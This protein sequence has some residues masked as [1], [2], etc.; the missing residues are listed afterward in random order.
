M[1]RLLI[2]RGAKPKRGLLFAAIYHDAY[3]VMRV[4]IE[5]GFSSVDEV[6]DRPRQETALLIAICRNNME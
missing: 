4:L 6:R 2:E 5:T 3:D 1:T